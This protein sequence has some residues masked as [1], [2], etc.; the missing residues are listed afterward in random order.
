MYKLFFILLITYSSL[1]SQ[2]KINNKTE[3]NI[4][5]IGNSL[6]Y[7][8][9]LPQLIK[10]KAKSKGVKINVKMIAFPNYAIEGHWNDGGIQKLI[11]NKKYDYVIIQQRPSS[12]SNGR[13]MLI[14]WS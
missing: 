7:K 12:Q 9:K 5:F 3:F 13:K 2:Q 11:S 4:L 14:E 6:T 1:Y 8:N 10:K